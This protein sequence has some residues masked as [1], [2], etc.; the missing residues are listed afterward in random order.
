ME[1]SNIRV[2][3]AGG[4]TGGHVY[5]ALA[6]IEALKKQG[7]TQFLYV[8]G[9]KG[10]ETK[11]VPKYGIPMETI[12]I[13]GI[14]RSFTLKNLLFPFKMMSSLLNSWRIVSNFKPHV[15]I[16]TGGYVSGPILFAAAK[17]GVPV[18]IQ[19]QDVH[20]GVTT[21]LLAKY[22]KTICLAFPAAV[23][24][25]RE[26]AE[27]LKV[28]GNPVRQDLGKLSKNEGRDIWKLAQNRQTIF[29]FGG[30]QGARSINIAM[31]NL[32]P[33]LLKTYDLQVIWQTGESQ[34]QS[35]VESV[36][37]DPKRVKVVPYVQDMDAAYAVADLVICRAGALTL[38]ELAIVQKPAILIP[39]PFAAGDHQIHNSRMI[40]T[41]GAATMIPEGEGWESRLQSAI[42]NALN[43]PELLAQQ[44]HAWQPLARPNAARDI[45]AAALSL[46]EN[47]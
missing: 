2:L 13:S 31:Q 32:L 39:Y 29:I 40:E 7:V 41:A 30:S 21:R 33:K 35:V 20:P 11:I 22:A 23:E 27:K 24:K 42:E 14:A 26:M 28:T 19:E 43:K 25:F 45:A 34:Y 18:L 8:G 9:K 47:R 3:I 36:A 17:R 1:R 15:A 10:I 46:V 37:I 6:T 4:G 5:P 44:Q 12:W 16:G 38:A